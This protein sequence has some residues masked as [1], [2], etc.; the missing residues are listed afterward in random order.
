MGFCVLL[1]PRRWFVRTVP[2]ECLDWLLI[3]NRRHLD[4]VPRVFVEHYNTR[5]THR[6]LNLAPPEPSEPRVD[7]VRA[8]NLAA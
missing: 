6:S 7:A 3:M 8:H 5:R 2:S 4:R 1:N